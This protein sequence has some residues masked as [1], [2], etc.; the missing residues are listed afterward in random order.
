MIQVILPIVG[1]GNDVVVM[2]AKLDD[3]HWIVKGIQAFDNGGLS[4]LKK[5]PFTFS[6][7]GMMV[8]AV[9]YE[10]ELPTAREWARWA[11]MC[12]RL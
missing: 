12:S 2:E 6:L 4:E 8:L 5:M 7:D 3:N 1:E 9:S 10:K 11:K